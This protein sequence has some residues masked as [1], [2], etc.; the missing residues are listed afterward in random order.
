MD[1]I[2][3]VLCLSTDHLQYTDFFKFCLAFSCINFVKDARV[4]VLSFPQRYGVKL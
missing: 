1:T 2:L 4:F 3:L